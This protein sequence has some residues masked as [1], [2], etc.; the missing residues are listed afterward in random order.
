[1]LCGG[2]DV[3]LGGGTRCD[4]MWCGLNV[5]YRSFCVYTVLPYSSMRI[6][7]EK[8]V[9]QMLTVDLT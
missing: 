9:E 3:M 1:M 2:A 8:T 7:S 4:V 5:N 6:C